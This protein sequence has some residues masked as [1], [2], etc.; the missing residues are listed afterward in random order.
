MKKTLTSLLLSLAATLCLAQAIGS[1][2]VYPSYWIATQNLTVGTRVYALMNG[3]LLCYD[4]EDTSV[5]LYDCLNDLNDVHISLIAYSEEAKRL[6]LVYEDG[7]IDLLDL[8]DNVWNLSGL[9]DS[10]LGDK[11][12]SGIAIDGSTAYLTTGFGFLTVD[13]SEG[14]IRDTYNLS[15][16]LTGILLEGGKTYVCTSSQVYVASSTDNWHIAS[17]WQKTTEHKVAEVAYQASEYNPA[18]GL[19]WHSDGSQGLCGYQRLSD[20]TYQLA[21]G[22]IQPNSPVRDLCYH[23]SYAGERLLI[24]GGINTNYAIYYPATAMYLDQDGTW[25]NFDEETPAQLYPDTHHYNT[26]DLV[27]DPLDPTHHYAS[28][29]RS[30][31]Y[32]YRDAQFVTLYNHL[33]SPLQPMNDYT[34]QSKQNY[35]SAVCLTYDTEGN[36]WMANQNTDTIVRLLTPEGKWLSLYYPDIA[37]T[38]NCDQYLFTTSGVNFLVCRRMDNRGF[39]A[40]TTGGTLT[41][42]SD[43]QHQLRST[44]TN[45]DGTSYTPDQFYCLEED[46]DGRVWCGTNLGLFVIDDPTQY[47]QSDFRFNQ[48]KINRDDGSGLADYL[49]SGVAVS[50]IA[51]DAAN[52]KWI[53]TSSNGLYLVSADGTEMLQHFQASDSPLLSDN[54]QCLAL[55]PSDGMLMIGT[56]AGLC[57]YMSDAEPAREELSKDNVLAYPN[58][59]T[60]G[61]SGVVTIDGLSANSEVKILTSTGQL[62]ARVYSNGGRATWRP[63]ATSGKPLASGVYNVVASDEAGKKAVVTRI[64]VIR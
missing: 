33:N 21:S 51:V 46:L 34:G 4:T 50:C 62:V 44:L 8:D 17:S 11:T 30:G 39:F 56:D 60:P 54:I 47:F 41:T 20:G 59:V 24:A 2:Q 49:L 36:L 43:D 22:P 55:N 1:W 25:T 27:E 57:S 12:V 42:T 63:V 6:I 48:I 52:R 23:M 9:K 31:L 40:F 28:P 29:Y 45:E 26:T 10:S 64:V 14:V 32:E 53:G 7:N 3:N 5:R 37:A 18:G 19:Y 35:V 13:M 15:L 61:Y 16:S 38:P 58:P